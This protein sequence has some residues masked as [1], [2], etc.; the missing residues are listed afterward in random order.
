MCT[1]ILQGIPNNGRIRHI[2]DLILVCTSVI[3]SCSVQHTAV[4]SNMYEEYGFPP[5]YPILL[6]GAPPSDKVRI[7]VILCEL[8]AW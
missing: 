3:F 5:N 2:D 8:T 1:C 4:T 7:F 6:H